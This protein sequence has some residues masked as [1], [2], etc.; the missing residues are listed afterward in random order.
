MRMP[1]SR[2]T[3][4]QI[5]A[6]LQYKR[7][8][9]FMDDFE[10]TVPYTITGTGSDFSAAI[11][12]SAVYIGTNGMLMATRTTSPAAD[13]YV[14]I[15]KKICFGL[16]GRVVIRVRIGIVTIAHL[17]DFQIFISYCAGTTGFKGGIKYDATIPG[18]SYYNSAG[19][20][21]SVA[22]TAYSF[23][24]DAWITVELPIDMG[25]AKYLPI[26]FAGHDFDFSTAYMSNEGAINKRQMT[27]E[28]V[29]TAAGA[30][31]TYLRMDALY[32]GEL[33]NI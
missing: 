12:T 14:S 7:E 33:V 24:D 32:V 13:D 1:S 31:K 15:Q 25:S 20:W 9:M 29:A 8:V 3:A 10:Q 22:G 4:N 17:K 16:S 30:N 18:I 5:G 11:A 6:A 27:I 19:G 2:L 28:F 26:T 21:T 23:E